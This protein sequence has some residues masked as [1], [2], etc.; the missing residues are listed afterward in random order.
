MTRQSAPPSKAIHAKKATASENKSP[1][2]TTVFPIV[3]IGASAGGLEAFEIF[4]EQMQTNSGMAFVLIAH[5][6]PTH[7]SILPELIQK[8]TKMKVTQVTDNL[9]VQKNHVYIIPPNKELSI[10][11]GYLQL[12]ELRRPRGL[13]LPIDSFFRSLAKDQGSN[14]ICIILSGTG[15]DGTLGLRAVKGEAGMSMVQTVESA[16]YSG[17]PQ[18]AI[19]TGL[20]DFVLP[21]EKIPEQLLKYASYSAIGS[22][23][24]A[25]DNDEKVKI[26]LN[27]IFVLL[28]SA[29][30][31][32][33]S[34][35]KTNTICRRIERRMH[36]HQLDEIADYVRYLQ[37][38]ERETTILFKEL[39]I[40][41]TSFFRDPEAYAQLQNSFVPK[42]FEGKPDDSQLRVWVP[43]CSSGEEVYSIAMLLQECMATR[44]RHFNIQ[45]FGT[46]ID[47]E[48]INTA[49][50]GIYPDSISA[51]VS[52][53]R[54]KKFF[55]KEEN[56]YQ[57]KKIIREMVIFAPQNIIKDPPFTKLDM[58]CCRNLLIYFGQ[59]LQNKL[60]PIFQ[61]SL[62]QEGILFLGSSESLGHATDLFIPL[63]K[64]WKIFKRSRSGS[65]P[66][67]VLDFPAPLPKVEVVEKKE[68]HLFSRV[69]NVNTMKLMRSILAQSD[70]PACAVID[71]NANIIYI[72]GRTGKYLEPAEGE[73]SVNILDMARPGLK[74]GLTNAINKMSTMRSDIVVKG[75]Q[76]KDNGNTLDIDLTIRPLPDF[77]TGCRGMMMVIF[78]PLFTENKAVNKT[79]TPN[80]TE[81]SAGIKRL[82]DELLYTKENLQTTIEELE[83]SNEELKSTNEELQSTNEELQSTN[84]E[85]E[86]SKE[87]LQ[88]LNE[89]SSTVNA[90]LQSRI[91]ELVKANDDIKNLLDGTDIATIFLDVDLAVRRFTPSGK[92]LFPLTTTDIGRP[93]NHFASNLIDIDLHHFSRQVLDDLNL[94]ESEVRDNDGNT[95]RMRIRPYRTT[96]NV[97][98]GVVITFE[99]ITKIKSIESQLI[100]VSSSFE[101]KVLIMSKI[102]MDG[103]DPIIIEDL[104][105][106]IT[107]VNEEA[108]HA[109]GWNRTELLGKKALSL[110][111]TNE[112]DQFTKLLTK[113]RQGKA[114]RNIVGCRLHKS[115]EIIPVILT[116]SLLAG[117]NGDTVA[118]ATIAK[119]TL[120]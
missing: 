74:A 96:N 43:G 86:T 1:P 3:A 49:R 36:V 83:T 77:Q 106:N 91:E 109:Y 76:I 78:E 60:L 108:V 98:D 28:R 44:G 14:A 15:T 31:H 17:M 19:A 67:P 58:L 34:L 20:A 72:H 66:R 41:V 47:E 115:G 68:T 90:E 104:K 107:D 81:K 117:K 24:S 75:I 23:Y 27:K 30:A 94:Y 61:Y 37:D 5:L 87:E 4:F 40:G 29:T 9:K 32:D 119:S 85:L 114:V 70:I 92:E 79:S 2:L 88:S 42:L 110:I 111:P 71:D 97:I 13:N 10:L 57:I 21:V 118:I 54:L 65:S 84:E 7:S 62:K 45:I 95:Y 99:D 12:L 73:A 59:E 93:I 26:S 105:G 55:T 100:S 56:H 64:K 112:Q 82:E 51:D 35:Y 63:D 103:A 38:S 22:P 113:C 6:D 120:T 11:N 33:F 89:E 116:F 18:S 16:Q 69:D 8:K 50:A 52:P 101:D 25:Y 80:Q 46:D 39:L 48:A 102:F 53:Q